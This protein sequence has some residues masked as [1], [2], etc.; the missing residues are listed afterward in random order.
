[1]KK[2]AR[3]IR[4]LFLIALIGALTAGAVWA[5]MEAVGMIRAS[6]YFNVK[7]VGVQGII[8]ADREKIDSFAEELVGKNIF[9]LADTVSRPEDPWVEKL[10]LRKVFPDSI[11]VEVFE[12][13]PV[14]QVEMY[15]RCYTATA[16]GSEIPAECKGDEVYRWKDVSDEEFSS[17]LQ[18]YDSLET[19]RKGNI[20]LKPLYFTLE[21]DGVEIKC[22]YDGEGLPQRLEVYTRLI[23]QRYKRI[24]YVDMRL[25]GKIYVNGVMNVSG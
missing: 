12:E 4:I 18:M 19:L 10:E 17:F 25:P 6:G 21:L 16:S 8:Q 9:S 5:A 3:V 24:E 13:R 22:G 1:M 2:L 14:A 15:D 11:E 20:I 7:H 23:K